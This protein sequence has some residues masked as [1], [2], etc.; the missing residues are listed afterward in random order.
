MNGHSLRSHARTACRS[1]NGRSDNTHQTSA[2]DP[3]QPFLKTNTKGSSE[4][5]E[6]L[7]I[8]DSLYRQI[9]R[10]PAHP[11]I[12]GK[13]ASASNARTRATGTPRLEPPYSGSMAAFTATTEPFMS[14][15]GPPLPPWVVSASYTIVARVT[16][17]TMPW[18]ASGAIC[19]SSARRAATLQNPVS[20]VFWSSLMKASPD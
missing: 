4:N 14:S 15:T 12:Q 18:L 3:M 7:D 19:P 2:V 20:L 9:S 5:Q 10:S 17:P 8:Q 16:W 1:E 11:G 6:G 13:P